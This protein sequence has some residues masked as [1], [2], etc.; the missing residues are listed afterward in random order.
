MNMPGF[1]AQA[2]LSKTSGHYQTHK[3]SNAYGATGTVQ[4]ALPGQSFPDH[5]CTCKGC[6]DKRGDVTGQCA[7]VCKDKEVFDKGSESYDYCKASAKTRPG[8]G[9]VFGGFGGGV[10]RFNRVSF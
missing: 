9:S 2:S 1:T 5:K 10:I 4:P 6:G 8:L 7:S 3:R